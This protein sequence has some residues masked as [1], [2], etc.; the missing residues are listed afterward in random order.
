MVRE[1]KFV[2]SSSVCDLL[3]AVS[4]TRVTLGTVTLASAIDVAIMTFVSPFGVLS[5]AN[6]CSSRVRFECSG[7]RT[8]PFKLSSLRVKD[9][10]SETPGK[11]TK[12][13]P[14]TVRCFSTADGEVVGVYELECEFLRVAKKETYISIVS[15]ELDPHLTF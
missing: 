1:V 4:I 3:S 15:D 7:V 5:N 11:N 8:T 10:I 9:R 12:T 14:S 2:V 13:S 6:R